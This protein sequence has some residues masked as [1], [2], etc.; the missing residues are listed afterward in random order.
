MNSRYFVFKSKISQKLV[1]SYAIFQN[2]KI[3]ILCLNVEF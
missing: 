2:L 1:L 3:N